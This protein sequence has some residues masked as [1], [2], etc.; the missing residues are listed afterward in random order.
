MLLLAGGGLL[1][2]GLLLAHFL[3][4]YI[5]G[6]FLLVCGSVL[7]QLLKPTPSH[8]PSDGKGEDLHKLT[9]QGLTSKSLEAFGEPD[10][11]VVGS[12]IGGL[13][14]GSLLAKQGKKVLILEQHDVAGGCCHVF[15]E[16]GYEFD[17]GLHYVGGR[18][19]DTTSQ[20]RRIFDVVT[21]GYV[22]WAKMDDEYDQV[23]LGDKKFGFCSGYQR[24]VTKLKDRFPGEDAAIDGYFDMIKQTVNGGGTAIM[25]LQVLPLWLTLL[26]LPLVDKISSKFTQQT[27]ADVLNSL[28][29]NKELIAVLS[30]SFGDYGLPPAQSSWIIHALVASHYF[31]GAAYPVGGSGRIA[32]GA[33]RVIE[34]HGGKVFVRAPV[35]EVI[36]ENGVCVG[37]K[38]GRTGQFEIRAKNVISACGLWNT[39]TKLLPEEHRSEVERPI[40][41]MKDGLNGVGTVAPSCG[42]LSLFVGFKQAEGEISLDLPRSNAW[43]FNDENHDKNVAD[44][45]ALDEYTDENL[46][47]IFI[48]FPSAKD[49]T[50]QDRYPDRHT[51]LCITEAPYKWFE[52]WE[53]EKVKNRGPG[54]EDLKERLSQKILEGMFKRYPHLKGKVDFYELGTPLSN[55]YYLGVHH[56][57]SYGLAHTPARFSTK[58]ADWIRTTTPFQGLYVA[59]QDVAC[60]GVAGGVI[61]GLFGAFQVS[62]MVGWTNLNLLP[63]D[64]HFLS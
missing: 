27:T 21:D 30:Y 48:S 19:W 56:G 36:I 32:E 54:Y 16:H 59:G 40:Q 12:G 62:K 63:P 14:A 57:E 58:N 34:K 9:R 39:Y 64:N 24:L 42:H 55:N 33:V 2:I 17:T 53:N 7:R 25:G 22:E 11:V 37:V 41:V 8:S 31:A 45:Y 13:V 26:L 60:A 3:S 49:P 50:Y 29:N 43:C 6:L 23:F 28:T 52:N 18:I 44:Y 1:L 10:V 61:G 38:A 15:E 46:P 35:Q 47:A 51:A 20:L 4:I 5:A